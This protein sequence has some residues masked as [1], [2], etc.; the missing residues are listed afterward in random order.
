[1]SPDTGRITTD[2]ECERPSE[3]GTARSGEIEGEKKQPCVRKK[4]GQRRT[5][6]RYKRFIVASCW[7]PPPPP[8]PISHTL[9]IVHAPR[10][11]GNVTGRLMTRFSRTRD[12][13]RCAYPRPFRARRRVRAP[14][15]ACFYLFVTCFVFYRRHRRH[16]RASPKFWRRQKRYEKT[17]TIPFYYR[18]ERV[19]NNNGRWPFERRSRMY[20]DKA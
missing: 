11:L 7:T 20:V 1:M 19:E 16:I 2:N 5:N 13:R 6:V 10:F 12:T 17:R 15:A 14:M 18:A 4:T 3:E 9:Y 8:P